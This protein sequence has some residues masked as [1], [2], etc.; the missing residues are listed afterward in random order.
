M[1]LKL[2]PILEKKFN[3][4]DADLANTEIPTKNSPTTPLEKTCI[5]LSEKKSKSRG[6]G[7]NKLVETDYSSATVETGKGIGGSSKRKRKAW[8]T[9]KEI[10]ENSELS[11][12]SKVSKFAIPFFMTGSGL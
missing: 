2:K 5:D 10:A 12:T 8:S 6:P 3:K 7:S 11:S 1:S 9:L 4:S